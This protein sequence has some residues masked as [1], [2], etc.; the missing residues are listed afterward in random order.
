M[1]PRTHI[2]YVT[3]TQHLICRRGSVNPFYRLQLV[4]T[5]LS[6]HVSYAILLLHVEGSVNAALQ[7]TYS[8]RP[9]VGFRCSRIG[10]SIWQLAWS[11]YHLLGPTKREAET[12]TTHVRGHVLDCRCSSIG[13]PSVG[14]CHHGMACPLDCG[15]GSRPPDMEVSCKYI[16]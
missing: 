8:V 7:Y 14:S 3:D 15:W 16:E 5:Y 9:V 11:A 10:W 12:R 13:W 2:A 1:S 6:M 4:F